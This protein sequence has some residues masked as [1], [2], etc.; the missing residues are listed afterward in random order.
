MRKG[1]L[2]IIVFICGALVMV[3]ELVGARIL[4]P[5]IGTS[6]F[7]WT[8]LIG[9]I[10]GSLSIGYWLGGILSDRK[11]SY[12]IFAIIILLSGIFILITAISKDFTLRFLTARFTDL[13]LLSILSSLILFAP[14]SVFLG[15]VSPYAVRLKLKTINTSGTTIGNL[16]AISTIGSIAGTFLA[17]FYLIPTFG[18]TLIVYFLSVILLLISGFLG[19]INKR[20][21]LFLITVIFLVINV[22]FY[23]RHLN[24]QTAYIDVDTMYN[25]VLIYNTTDHK[26]GRKIKMLRINDERSAAM[27]LDSDEL[28]FKVLNYYNL[29]AHFK[30]DFKNT[31][32]IGGSGYSY[33]KYF[34]SKFPDAT[35][36]VVEIDPAL[37]ELAKK[38]F[39]L[40]ENRRL[41]IIHE[42]GR[43]FL[44]NNIRKYDVIFM[45]AYK[46]Q[47][48]IPYQLTTLE[49]VRLQYDAL[50]EN[51][52]LLANIISNI[53][54]KN[55]LFLL[56]ELR[57]YREI[58]PQVF[59]FAVD[60]PE[61]HDRLQNLML[62]ALKSDIEPS[63]S[64]LD[65]TLN[66]Y[67]KNKVNY[68]FILNLP[69]LTDDHAPVEF[70][71]NKA[72]KG[73]YDKD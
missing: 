28:V 72:I 18:N 26:T 42:D 41:K 67:L 46:S 23:L 61:D 37:T 7:V 51:G 68:P 39:G 27:F 62:V 56:A 60:D 32:M 16:Y 6:L 44:N 66:I 3:F 25:R 38:H 36:D 24:K 1:L 48:T 33:P 22:I 73:F 34:L 31:L 4:G 2:E 57:T 14:G 13:R 69:V 52:V 10:L 35:I 53:R 45:D 5:Y 65:S 40:K 20:L 55:N 64:N 21:I 30:P 63:F 12:T 70:Y 58:F 29:A 54:G 50:K 9:I 19:V 15:M 11:P 59:L 49:A 17:G 47:L 8:S 43:T 71:A